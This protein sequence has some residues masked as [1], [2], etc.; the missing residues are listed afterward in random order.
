MR[1]NTAGAA[2]TRYRPL[3]DTRG[4]LERGF[5]TAAD[6]GWRL[7]VLVAVVGIVLWVL[8]RLYLVTVPVLVALVLSTLFVPSARWLAR[9]GMPSTLAAFVAVVGGALIGLAL[10]A[11]VVTLFVQQAA[12]MTDAVTG[13]RS[14][15]LGWLQNGPLGLSS[16]QVS[17][18]VGRASEQLRRNAG[19]IIGGVFASAR[20]L[21]EAVAGAL[22]S[23]VL[24]FF[25]VKDGESMARWMLARLPDRHTELARA[26]GRR[27]WDTLS[28]Y[29]HGV[30][31]IAV[32]E[33]VAIGTGLLLVGM[34]LALPLAVFVFFGGFFP[35]VGAIVSGAL[36]VLA[37]LIT[38]G[39]TQALIIVGLVVG[40]QQL[41]GYLL[42]PFVMRRTVSL[43]P[44]V[45]LVTL[46]AGALL[47]GIAGAAFAVPLAAVLGA[48]GNEV[49][50]HHQSAD[51][52]DGARPS[53][54][55]APKP[56][57]A[58]IRDN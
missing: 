21:T 39:P 37:T 23:V 9:R 8:A 47:G 7:L 18:L 3:P 40:V 15:V 14:T 22:L 57:E 10:I 19:A 41:D 28:G 53:A 45:V 38:A 16:D 52:A 12:S 42:H 17:D 51:G 13:M 26:L 56:A 46:T 30:V 55:V 25:F 24:L 48:V 32:V 35:T 20:L 4:P 27:T 1:T 44:V 43:H 54:G 34:P 50:L 6:K 5:D 49:R 11:L 2:R 33:A 29:V 36:A 31:I 58:R